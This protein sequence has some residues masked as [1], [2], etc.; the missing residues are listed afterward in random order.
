MRAA[1]V[2]AS[3]YL[4]LVNKDDE[5]HDAALKL[6]KSFRGLLVTTEYVL[7][8]VLDALT[9]GDLRDLGLAIVDVATGDPST[10]VVASGSEWFERG[11]ELFRNRPDKEWGI[12]DCISFTV[13]TDRAIRECLTADKHFEQ[14]G[15]DA[16]LRS[17]K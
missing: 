5:Y 1:F 17:A 3:F 10:T 15:F 11:R 16:L 2:D 7:L 8:E 9:Q 14:A 13:M 4:A 6:Q 12:T